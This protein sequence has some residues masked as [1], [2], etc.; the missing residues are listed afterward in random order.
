MNNNSGIKW[1]G[2]VFFLLAA[3][4]SSFAQIVPES[5]D[6]TEVAP[7]EGQRQLITDEAILNADTIPSSNHSPRKATLFSAALPGL[8]QAYNKKYWKIPLIYGGFATLIYFIDYNN[9]RYNVFRRGLFRLLNDDS[10][11]SV[12]LY[13]QEFR[14]ESLRLN[15]SSFR[16]DRDFLIILTGILYLLNITDA[17]VDAHLKEFDLTPELG[18]QL[19]PT[20]HNYPSEIPYSGLALTLKFK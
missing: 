3:T 20:M 8:G 13:G 6:T 17:L 5:V 1:L 10:Q 2:L 11:V 15:I 14:E 19:K 12:L 4:L 16:R 7:I 9:E 18:L